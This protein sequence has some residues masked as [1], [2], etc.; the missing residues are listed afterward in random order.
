[1]LG[2]PRGE[3]EVVKY[4]KTWLNDFITEKELIRNLKNIHIKSIEH[5]GSTSI[6]NMPAKPILDLMVGVDIFYNASKVVRDLEK[7]GYIWKKDVAKLAK[8]LTDK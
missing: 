6:P 5:I 3:V 8:R 4:Q 7:I 2:L 1:M